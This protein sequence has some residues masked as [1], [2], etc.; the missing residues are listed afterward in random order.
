MMASTTTISSSSP[1]SSSSSS[2][3]SSTLLIS[4]STALRMRSD[5]FSSAFEHA[6]NVDANSLNFLNSSGEI[7]PSASTSSI[8]IKVSA[9][10]V[11]VFV[12][13]FSPSS[14][15]TSFTSSESSSFNQIVSI[16]CFNSSTDTLPLLSTSNARKSASSASGL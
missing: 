6:L 1:S 11:V 16:V 8:F 10:S 13:A 12:V 2:S 4:T 7:L 5:C 3:S 14:S 9:V 15:Y